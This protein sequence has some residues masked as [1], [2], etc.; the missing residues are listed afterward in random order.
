MDAGKLDRLIVIEQ[1]TPTRS[2]SGQ[3]VDV[4]TTFATVYAQK[5]DVGGKEF[6]GGGGVQAQGTTKWRIRWLEG[7][8]HAMRIVYEGVTYD[9]KDINEVPRRYRWDIVS[10]AEVT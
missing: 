10:T 1:N 4:W 8:T 2:G 6:F 7:L 5:M 3:N 9:I